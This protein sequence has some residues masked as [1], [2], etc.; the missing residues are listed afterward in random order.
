MCMTKTANVTCIIFL[1]F[2]ANQV[3][4]SSD[5]KED[6]FLM[7]KQRAKG[8]EILV[9]E[10]FETPM[11]KRS[12]IWVLK[13]NEKWKGG[14]WWFS[15]EHG[16]IFCPYCKE[17]DKTS[18]SKFISG[19]DSMRIENVHSYETSNADRTSHSALNSKR[20]PVGH[21]MKALI[22]IEKHNINLTKKQFKIAYFCDQRWKAVYTFCQANRTPSCKLWWWHPNKTLQQWQTNKLISS[23]SKPRLRQ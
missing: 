6:H 4:I 7:C 17:F 22:I 15:A 5:C 8:A 1:H 10:T 11:T 14:Q 13:F 3:W 19:C 20:P 16:K 2:F 12:N 21:L 23:Q 18:R 9:E